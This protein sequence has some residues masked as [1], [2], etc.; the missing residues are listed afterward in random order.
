MEINDDDGFLSRSGGIRGRALAGEQAGWNP[1]PLFI[2]FL[3]LTV[4]HFVP[5]IPNF[6][7]TLRCPCLP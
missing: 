6:L 1:M 2:I 4:L 7:R 5:Y 3:S